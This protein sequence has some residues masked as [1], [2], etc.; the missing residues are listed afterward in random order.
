M[1]HIEN[2]EISHSPECYMAYVPN[3]AEL[4]LEPLELNNGELLHVGD[5]F[6]QLGF[7]GCSY[8]PGI[9]VSKPYVQKY[10]GSVT[11]ASYGYD[12]DGMDTSSE[13]RMVLFTAY[14]TEN[15]TQAL[16]DINIK[17]KTPFIAYK[18]HDDGKSLDYWTK[19]ITLKRVVTDYIKR[20]DGQTVDYTVMK[21]ARGRVNAIKEQARRYKLRG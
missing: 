3:G 14:N 9:I 21:T 10:A 18:T 15:G 11:T 17:D 1:S 20:Y 6:I 13:V 8:K 16:G 4:N 7:R 5:E 19:S 12:A 2:L